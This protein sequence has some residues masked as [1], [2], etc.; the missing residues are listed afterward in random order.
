[1]FRCSRVRHPPEGPPVWAALKRFPFGMPPAMSWTTSPSV[2]PIGT[3]TMPVF[4]I[5][6]ARAKTFVP[7]LFGVPSDAN[8]APPLRT[9]TGT[10]A[11]VSTLL[12][13]VGLPKMPRS[14]GNGGFCRGSPRFPSTECMRAV[15]SPQTKAPAPIRI[16][17]SKANVVPMT[18]GP[19]RPHSR[20]CRIATS[21]RSTASGYSART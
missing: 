15:S 4:S 12:M 13:I 5:L 9:M 11:S 6:P 21:R 19:R 1:M 8:Q 20:A 14:K 17:T 10:F 18:F 2:I 3:S 7:L 16:S